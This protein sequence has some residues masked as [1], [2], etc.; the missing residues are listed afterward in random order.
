MGHLDT[1]RV[2]GRPRSVVQHVDVITA[3]EFWLKHSIG[4]PTGLHDLIKGQDTYLVIIL[5]SLHQRLR[6]CISV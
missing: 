1:F 6:F 4:L 2:A 5:G 3:E